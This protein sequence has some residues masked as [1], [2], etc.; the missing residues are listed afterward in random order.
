M[1]MASVGTVRRVPWRGDGK[2][3][4]PCEGFALASLPPQGALDYLVL[5]NHCQA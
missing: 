1:G 5:C 4:E 3:S 2:G